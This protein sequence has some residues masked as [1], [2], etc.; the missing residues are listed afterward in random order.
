MPQSHEEHTGARIARTRRERSLTQ[1]G[2]AMRANVSKSLLS[3]VECGQRPASPSLIAACAR[4]L[5][6]TTSDL[7]GQPYT[8]ELRR[9]RLDEVIQPIRVSMENWDIPLDWQV[10]PRPV[11]L[12]RA[13]MEKVLVQRR[14]AEYLPMAVDLPAL[15]DECVQAIH[16]TGG[17][18]RRQ[19]HECLAW[20][21]RCVFTLAWS[22]GYVDLATVALQRL[23]WAAPRADEPGLAAMYGY[24][25]AQTTLSSSR[26]DLGMRIVDSTL[27]DLAGQDAR[28]P[29][30][31]AAM[32][33]VLQLRAAVI[34]GRM[35][36]PDQVEARVT[37]ARELARR[38]G[39]TAAYGVGWGP[40]NVGVHA[41]AI[42]CDLEEY[43]QAVQLADGVRFPQRWD[44][45]RAGHHWLDLSRANVWTGNAAQALTCLQKARR[46]APQQTRYHPTTRETVIALRSRERSRSGELAE[47]SHWI[48]L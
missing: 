38:T 46:T 27:R 33:G 28:S 2:L 48:G 25:R 26:Y 21:F 3:K 15:I 30:G 10:P 23:D 13:D 6:V 29:H 42:A 5:S 24:L 18:E 40:T 41:V 7:L 16:T 9:E 31:L 39:E 37:E 8:Q 47:F 20:A 11:A 43:D 19:A 35:K 22:F 44:R 32:A 17:E 14:Q 12:I 45:S 4:A 1:Q 36:D 34:A